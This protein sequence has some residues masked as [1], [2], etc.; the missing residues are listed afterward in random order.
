MQ[1]RSGKSLSLG[2]VRML[3]CAVCPGKS[4]AGHPAEPI[5]RRQFEAAPAW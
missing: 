2:D 4:R 5:L 1:S 3:A